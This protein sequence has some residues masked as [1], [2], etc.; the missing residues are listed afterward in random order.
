MSCAWITIYQTIFSASSHVYAERIIIPPTRC[1]RQVLPMVLI[2]SRSEPEGN[3]SPTKRRVVYSIS[4]GKV[5]NNVGLPVPYSKRCCGSSHGWLATVDLADQP[6]NITLMNPFKKAATIRLPPL[7]SNAE[8]MI[9]TDHTNPYENYVRKV[10]LSADPSSSPDNYMVAS[11]Y[12]RDS[13]L[14]FTKAG[15]NY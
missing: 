14:S 1:W 13:V 11:L 15:Q 8:Y 7:E 5:Y 12:S 3:T 9:P 4:E 6:M 10:I 2:L